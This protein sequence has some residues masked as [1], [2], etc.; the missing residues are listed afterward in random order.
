MK[1]FYHQTFEY[2]NTVLISLLLHHI[3][4]VLIIIPSNIYFG[5][6]REI[7]VICYSLLVSSPLLAFWF[8]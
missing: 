3:P 1:K 2:S 7:Q 8:L 4:G 5:T 6:D